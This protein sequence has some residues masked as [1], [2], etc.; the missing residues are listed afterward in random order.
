MFAYSRTYRQNQSEHATYTSDE[1][2][3]SLSMQRHRMHDKISGISA[4]IV[5]TNARIN[6]PPSREPT[7]PV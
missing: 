7:W 4:R 3:F 6:K 2:E 1:F 5:L